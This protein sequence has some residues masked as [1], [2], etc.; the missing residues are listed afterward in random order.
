[1]CRNMLN[2]QEDVE[3]VVLYTIYFISRKENL[4]RL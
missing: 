1:M 3:E 2:S 4:K